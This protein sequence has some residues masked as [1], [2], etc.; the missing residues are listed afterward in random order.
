M[1]RRC[2]NSGH[3][4]P[5]SEQWSAPRGPPSLPWRAEHLAAVAQVGLLL[6]AQQLVVLGQALAPAGG[7][8]LQMAGAQADRQVRDEGVLG[9]A[10]AVRDEN[11]P[12]IRHAE[13]PRC[14]GLSDGADLID[15]Q[16]HRVGGLL[17]QA[18]LHPLHV[19]AVEVVA[20]NLHTLAHRLRELG[21]ALKV[22]L[23]EG[24]LEEGDG[25][26]LAEALV[27]LNHLLAGTLVLG[28]WARVLEIQVVDALVALPELRRRRV[29]AD[30]D[31]ACMPRGLDRLHQ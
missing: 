6:D 8:G 23:C 3:G 12:A 1:S 4:L 7:P 24:V 16:E 31:L 19:G 5:C 11:A 26:L 20:H 13:L 22:F 2:S 9:L 17:V 29:R 27:G 18:H 10:R 28:L 15:L 30:E 21:M 25:V 14:D